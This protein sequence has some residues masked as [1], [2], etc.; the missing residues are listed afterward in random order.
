MQKLK[1]SRSWFTDFKERSHLHSIK[2][3]GETPSAHVEAAASQPDLTA[4]YWKK[5]PS[6]TPIAREAK[7]M[8]GFKASK[9]RLIFLLGINAAGDFKLKSVVVYHP[10]NPRAL[11]NYIKPI[12]PVLYQW[13]N[14][15]QM[16]AHLFT[17]CITDYFKCIVETY[18]SE[19]G[20]LSEYYCS[21]TIYLVTKSSDGDVQLDSY[22]FYAC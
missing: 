1:A 15:A 22:C 14:K 19:K 9:N 12:L 10:E 11:K 4:F 2:M 5:M 3:Q 16:I 18:C 6:R 20:F 21:L 7:S 13:D 8:T 17:T